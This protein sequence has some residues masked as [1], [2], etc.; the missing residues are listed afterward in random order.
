M[1]F[2]EWVSAP[3]T[4]KSATWQG[5]GILVLM[6][7]NAAHSVWW[8]WDADGAFD[9]WYINLES[10]AARW[11]DGDLAGVDTVDHDLDVVARPDGSWQLKDED[12][13]TERLAYPDHYWVSDEAAVR[14]EAAR[15]IE[16][17]EARRYPFDGSW[18][19]F[20]PPSWRVPEA[21]PP[22]W[23]RPRAGSDTYR[24]GGS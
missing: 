6:P 20:R 23:D 2:L 8:F 22:G 14:A 16:A 24:P 15:V 1:P 12:E 10:P 11:D 4:I 19:D 21:L 18:C 5:Y 17:F 7:P 13:F 3:K 9:S